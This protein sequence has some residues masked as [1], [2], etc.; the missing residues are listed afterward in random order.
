MTQTRTIDPLPYSHRKVSSPI[1]FLESETPRRRDWNLGPRGDW[2]K[3]WNLYNELERLRFKIN[4]FT[5]IM[6]LMS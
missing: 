5:S 3:H 2:S 1:I 4:I 6:G